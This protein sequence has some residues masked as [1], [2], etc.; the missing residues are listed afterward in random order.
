MVQNGENPCAIWPKLT[1]HTGYQPQRPEDAE[2]SQGL[3]VE[4]L[5]LERGEDGAHHSEQEDTSTAIH[6]K[7]IEM[8]GNKYYMYSLATC[9]MYL[10]SL[11]LFDLTGGLRKCEVNFIGLLA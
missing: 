2:S 11:I 7:K 9:A 5:D 6:F 8:F 1:W 10:S 3:H 4:A